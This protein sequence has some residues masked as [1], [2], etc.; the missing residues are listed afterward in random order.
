MDLQAKGHRRYCEW[1]QNKYKIEYISLFSEFV[2]KPN[3]STKAEK[4]TKP[5]L[6]YNFSSL[7][8]ILYVR[9]SKFMQKKV[10]AIYNDGNNKWW[11][12]IKFN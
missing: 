12:I 11:Q 10:K 3:I 5:N 6:H 1:E 4:H 2:F 8:T 7:F 9:Q